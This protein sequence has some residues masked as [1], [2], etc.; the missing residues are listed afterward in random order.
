MLLITVLKILILQSNHFM[1]AAVYTV[2]DSAQFEAIIEEYWKI[3]LKKKTIYLDSSIF[4]NRTNFIEKPLP[5]I[6]DR[7]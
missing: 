1:H 4:K 5:S 7:F 2:H 3:Y 6:N